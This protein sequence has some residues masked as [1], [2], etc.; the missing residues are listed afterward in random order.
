MPASHTHL[1]GDNGLRLK[2][3]TDDGAVW[4][5]LSESWNGNSCSIKLTPAQFD[6]LREAFNKIET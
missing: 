6:I 3:D 4:I 5:S 1:N 2:S